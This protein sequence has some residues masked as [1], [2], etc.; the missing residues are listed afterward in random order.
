[1]KLLITLPLLLQLLSFPLAGQNECYQ[2]VGIQT[3][4]TTDIFPQYYRTIDTLF[5]EQFVRSYPLDSISAAHYKTRND[6]AFHLTRSGRPDEALDILLDL[7]KQ[8]PQEYNIICNLGIAYALNGMPDSA[9][10]ILQKTGIMSPDGHIGSKWFFLKVAEVKVNIGKDSSWLRFNKVLD[11]G[12]T[13]SSNK[14]SKQY[15]TNVDNINALKQQLREYIQF[16]PSP[17][18]LVANALNELGQALASEYSLQQAYMIYYIGLQYGPPDT[19]GIYARLDEVKRSLKKCVLGVPPEEVL[20]YYF[21]PVDS[22]Q[23]IMNERGTY[24]S[25]AAQVRRVLQFRKEEVSKNKKIYIVALTAAVV[26]VLGF[27]LFFYLRK[28][29]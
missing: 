15:R 6:I 25:A 23:P 12:I 16:T 26:V 17:D 18:P 21:P 19:Y 2:N 9:L 27:G 11:L 3:G 29:R 20:S 22:I 24:S 13:Q 4:D 7:Y 5:S 1:M 10:A 28:R 8:Y 14:N